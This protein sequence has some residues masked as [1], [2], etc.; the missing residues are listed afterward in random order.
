MLPH[1]EA[2]GD[3]LGYG[4][5]SPLRISFVSFLQSAAQFPADDKGRTRQLFQEALRTIREH[6]DTSTAFDIA[7]VIC[8]ITRG[9]PTLRKS[10]LAFFSELLNT[11]PDTRD[12]KNAAFFPGLALGLFESAVLLD[13]LDDDSFYGFFPIAATLVACEVWYDDLLALLDSS[14]LTR[15]WEGRLGA[16]VKNWA[17]GTKIG[18]T[19]SPERFLELQEARL[20]QVHATLTTIRITIR[21]MRRKHPKLRLL[22]P[23]SSFPW[24]PASAIILRQLNYAHF[25]SLSI[26]EQLALLT[27]DP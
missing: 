19:G 21:T 11:A 25:G 12:S 16:A 14:A 26:E 10:W 22:P 2:L 6:C 9:Y 24:N 27:L 1:Q 13:A 4:R 3:L 15:R 17:R 18:E 23:S 7:A 5:P 8:A 20:H